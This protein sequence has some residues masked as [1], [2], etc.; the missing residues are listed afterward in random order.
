MPFKRSTPNVWNL[1]SKELHNLIFF[2]NGENRYYNPTEHCTV[3][4]PQNQW[5]PFFNSI[6][7]VEQGISGE[8]CCWMFG[9]KLSCCCCCCCCC[10]S[11]SQLNE[12]CFRGF[13]VSV[14]SGIVGGWC[15]DG[16]TSSRVI[17]EVKQFERNQSSDGYNFLGSGECCCRAI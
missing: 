15:Q 4:E 1:A 11:C 14:V 9:R 17:T 3:L 8:C 5:L 10:C 6:I 12:I 13:Q 2:M 7:L 16:N